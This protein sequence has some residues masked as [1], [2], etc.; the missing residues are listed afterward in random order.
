MTIREAQRNQFK[1]DCTKIPKY[2]INQNGLRLDFDVNRGIYVGREILGK[3]KEEKPILGK[4]WIAAVQDTQVPI[5][6]INCPNEVEKNGKPVLC[7][8]PNIIPIFEDGDTKICTGCKKEFKAKIKIS[9]T[10]AC[11]DLLEEIRKEGG[12]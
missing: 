11:Y 7:N 4:E 5:F 8:V 9:K 2:I 12:S 6:Y 3:D 10:L 1:K